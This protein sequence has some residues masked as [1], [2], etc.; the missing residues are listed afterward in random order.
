MHPGA[1]VNSKL[2]NGHGD[3]MALLGEYEFCQRY[4]LALDL[5]PRINGDGGK[6]GTIATLRGEFCWDVKTYENPRNLLVTSYRCKPRVIY[7]LAQY[8][9]ALDSVSLLGWQWGKILLR[10]EAK[11]WG[12]KGIISYACLAKDLRPMKDLDA[13]VL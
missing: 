7:V 5:S 6:D 10:G 3:Y 11:D 12:G 4:G 2:A 13:L 8:F 1:W 9:P